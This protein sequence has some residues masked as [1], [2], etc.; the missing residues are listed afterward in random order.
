MCTTD[1]SSPTLIEPR[2]TLVPQQ[3]GPADSASMK[4]ANDPRCPP[5]ANRGAFRCYTQP[6]YDDNS[7]LAQ[8]GRRS[9]DGNLR[10]SRYKRSTTI[11][12]A[13]HKKSFD[14]CTE[15]QFARRVE[16]AIEEAVGYWSASL[17]PFG[18]RFQR[19]ARDEHAFFLVLYKKR[20]PSEIDPNGGT[21]TNKKYAKA[22][23]PDSPT[24]KRKLRV[25]TD[26][27]SAS[28]I[29]GRL[30]KIMFHELGHILGLRHDD[31]AER[32]PGNPSFQLSPPNQHSIMAPTVE[33]ARSDMQTSDSDGIKKLYNLEEGR[34]VISRVGSFTVTS[35]NPAAVP[36]HL[37]WPD[38]EEVG[39]G[40]SAEASAAP[41]APEPPEQDP[42]AP[43]LVVV[44]VAFLLYVAVN[45]RVELTYSS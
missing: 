15:P 36:Q 41:P 43:V 7:L 28:S 21:T 35:I 4:A 27:V 42:A 2:H 44:C 17:K 39:F 8:G 31:A 3:L 10:I 24:E 29:P 19:V 38:R 11:N 33:K 40:A 45:T 23:F 12:Y 14:A 34:T 26:S 20:P 37:F 9:E 32:E 5:S 13:F 18:I 30:A 1:I 25:Y 22:F 6:E 16:N